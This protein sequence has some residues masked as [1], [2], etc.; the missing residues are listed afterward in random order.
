MPSAASLSKATVPSVV[1]T[2]T[3]TASAL[4]AASKMSEGMVVDSPL[5]EMVTPRTKR[6]LLRPLMF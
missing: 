6:L 3:D 1:S 5:V 2:A 4:S